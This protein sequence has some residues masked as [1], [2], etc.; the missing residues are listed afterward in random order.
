MEN[1]IDGSFWWKY[2]TIYHIYPQSFMDSNGD[3]WGDL[4]GIIAKFDYLVSLGIDAI[5]LSP[6]YP[7]PMYDSGYDITDYKDINPIFGSMSDFKTLL[8][9]AHSRGIKII[10]DLVLNHTSSQHPWFLESRQA[11]DNPK[12]DWYIWESPKSG[13]KPNNWMTNFGQSAWTYDSLTGEYY[14][15]SF[16]KEQPDLNWR[17]MD[18]R[19]AMYDIIRF[20]LD[21]GVDGFRL[22]VINLIFK[23]KHLRKNPINFLFNK[24]KVYNRNRPSVCEVLTEFRKILD[25]YP[26]KTSVGEIYS[27][28]PGDPD[29]TAKFQG[30]GSDML[31]MAF[32][33]STFFARWDALK[34]TEIISN[35]YRALPKDGWPC[36]VFSNHDLGRSTNRWMFSIYKQ[37]RAKIRAMLLLTLKGT[38]FIY[39]GDEIGMENVNISRSQIHDMY[40]KLFYPFYKGRD[41]YR[42]P[43]QWNRYANAGFSEGC[44]WLPVH[45]NYKEVNVEREDADERS[46]LTLYKRLI[47][48]RKEYGVLQSG[49]F[50]FLDS[51][52]PQ[53]MTYIRY[54][55][56]ERMIVLLNFSS[57]RQKVVVEDLIEYTS[58]F[59]I[60]D[61]NAKSDG[62]ITRDS[63]IL[64]AFDGCILYRKEHN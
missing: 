59:S 22:D 56:Y 6:I 9:L 39:Y 53:V 61:V 57:K 63:V 64:K 18:L 7:S 58:L 40:G 51:G 27:P 47:Q 30:N 31:H 4:N 23:D 28:P 2:G 38:P 14:Y 32:D 33:F 46:I 12:R 8:D 49:E 5:W 29:L 43:M 21:M 1:K 10:M 34:Y 41:A 3:G 19:A 37:E 44:T 16:F 60:L 62:L 36:F 48:I 25:E 45:K 35:Y 13:K 17:N 11:K 42:T 54:S 52:N 24:S 26:D 15:H 55:K 20:W 50:E